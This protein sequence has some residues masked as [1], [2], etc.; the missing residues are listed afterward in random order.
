MVEA[1]V[2]RLAYPF[3]VCLPFFLFPPSELLHPFPYPTHSGGKTGRARL[4]PELRGPLEEVAS[5]VL[6][7]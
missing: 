6:S 5:G 7:C 3:P 2:G 1:A 4:T